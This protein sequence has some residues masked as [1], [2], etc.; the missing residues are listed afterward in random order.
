MLMIGI[1]VGVFILWHFIP[2]PKPPQP[3]PRFGGD[4]R[5]KEDDPEWRDIVEEQCES[6]AETRFLATM[7]EAFS[8]LPQGGSLRSA[9]LKL[10]MQVGEGPYR[11]DFLADEWLVIEIDGAAFHSSPQ[12]QERDR[13]RDAYFEE[14]GYSVLRIPARVVFETP[15]EA[16]RRVRSALAVG[17]RPRVEPTPIRGFDRLRQT[18]SGFARVIQEVDESMSRRLSV[19]KAIADARNAAFAEKIAIDCAVEEAQTQLEFETQA[20]DDQRRIYEELRLKLSEHTDD[21]RGDKLSVP[22]FPPMPTH[23][24]PAT[25]TLIETAYLGIKAERESKLAK[26][27]RVLQQEPQLGP[28]VEAT[29]SRLGC[30]EV[31][32]RIS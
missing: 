9:D 14:L 19:E 26:A 13:L 29:L 1:L 23:D 7:V 6:P 32:G 20:T 28:L 27:R 21:E 31:W 2:Q 22:D 10:D 15:H 30:P 3:S 12:A 4:L 25:A 17:K 18:A 5:A 11:V 24:D 16:L 8:L